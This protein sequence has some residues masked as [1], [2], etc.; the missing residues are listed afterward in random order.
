MGGASPRQGCG[1]S[2]VSITD[3]VTSRNIGH[4]AAS[5][6]QASNYPTTS[7]A[8]GRPGCEL[9]W[10]GLAY[11]SSCP[12]T[13]CQSWAGP[14]TTSPVAADAIA[15]EVGH[16]IGLMHSLWTPTTTAPTIMNTAM[17]RPWIRRG[18]S[19]PA[20]RTAMGRWDGEDGNRRRERRTV[21][22]LASNQ[23]AAPLA[24]GREDRPVHRQPV[25]VSH[26]TATGYD[27]F[28]ASTY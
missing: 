1:C 27:S 3:S 11:V 19:A 2:A 9:R 6:R 7:T 24:S 22:P 16:N 28:L 15:H 5:R 4:G 8:S 20:Q 10:A 26:C 25:Y 21:H 23:P 14:T 17:T 13:Y 12:G 18:D